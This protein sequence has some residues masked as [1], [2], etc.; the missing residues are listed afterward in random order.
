MSKTLVIVGHP[1]ASS[2]CAALAEKYALAARQSGAE[3][4]LLYLSQLNFSLNLEAGYHAQQAMEPDLQGAQQ[5][6]EWCDHLCIVTPTWWSS[7]PALLK[8]FVDRTFLPGFA[9][10]YRQGSPLP[11]KLLTGRTA[12]LIVTTDTPPLLLRTLMGDPTVKS[13]AQGVLGFSGFKP[14]RVTRFGAIRN[15]TVQQRENWLTQTAEIVQQDHR[16][17]AQ[18]AY[19]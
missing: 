2:F 15:S 14:V 11:E 1:N 18:T 6:I 16:R 13:L 5:L 12:R 7:M 9:F 3:V 4:E 19:A 10:K 8:G 17:K